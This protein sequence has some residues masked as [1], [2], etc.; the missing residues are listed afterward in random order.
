MATG[1]GHYDRDGHEVAFGDGVRYD[2]DPLGDAQYIG[3]S[4]ASAVGFEVI[5][6]GQAAEVRF[7]HTCGPGQ[8]AVYVPSLGATFAGIPMRLFRKS[9][10]FDSYPDEGRP[11]VRVPAP[12]DNGICVCNLA[13]L[14][15][16]GCRCGAT[17][18][19]QPPGMA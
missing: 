10:R 2:P 8:L 6:V 4:W 12:K 11:Y 13:S 15:S 18:R 9:P 3:T 19:Y 5:S 1:T 17:T 14:M 7:D 16:D